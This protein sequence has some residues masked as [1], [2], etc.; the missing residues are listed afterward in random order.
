MWSRT[1]NRVRA[2]S[3]GPGPGM[4]PKLIIDK[5][6]SEAQYEDGWLCVIRHLCHSDEL[7]PSYCAFAIFSATSLA[8]L[9]A[10]LLLCTPSP[11]R[12]RTNARI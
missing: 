1:A 8:K 11:T 12:Y 5:A 7:P 6:A 10:D 2:S 9:S 4:N 3:A